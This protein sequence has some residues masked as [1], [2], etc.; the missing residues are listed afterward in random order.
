MHYT[1]LYYNALQCSILYYIVVIYCTAPVVLLKP[2]VEDLGSVVCP[3]PQRL[4]CDVVFAWLPGR[5]E[6]VVVAPGVILI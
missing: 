3:P 4:A 5:A 1:I 6:L 2:G